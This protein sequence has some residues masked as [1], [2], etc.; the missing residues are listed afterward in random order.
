MESLQDAVDDVKVLR[1]Q[2]LDHLRQESGPVS[3]EVYVTG[4]VKRRN[5]NG[6]YYQKKVYIRS[7]MNMSLP[8]DRQSFTELALNE[9]GCAEHQVD[10]HGLDLRLVIHRHRTLF[11]SLRQN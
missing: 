1:L 10:N 6:V 11:Q 2:L 9:Y 5:W 3:R 7:E 8:D 4:K